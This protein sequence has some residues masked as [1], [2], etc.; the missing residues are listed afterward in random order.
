MLRTLLVYFYALIAIRWIGGR[1]VGQLSM[2]EFVLVIA[3]GSAVGDAMFYPDVPLL[4]AFVVIT[5]VILV[6]KLLDVLICRFR[7]AQH[8][9]E[10]RPILLV[11]DGEILR[12]GMDATRLSPAEIEAQLRLKGIGDMAEV[13]LAILETSGQVSVFRRKP[14]A[15]LRAI[16][17]PDNLLNPPSEG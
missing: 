11:R 8:A 14:A 10:G 5:L 13:R 7:T 4:V 6:N 15:S 17:L 1:T 12:S 16:D 2:V 3:L 9:V